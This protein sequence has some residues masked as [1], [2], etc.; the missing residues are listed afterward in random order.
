MLVDEEGPFGVF[1]K[2]RAVTGLKYDEHSVAYGTNIF[3]KILSCLWCT[4]VWVGFIVALFTNPVYIH[5]FLLNSFAF[6]AGAIII[7]SLVRR[8]N[9][10]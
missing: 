4:S 5:T 7:D 6:S 2:L 9:E 3:S 8:I 1:V 10:T